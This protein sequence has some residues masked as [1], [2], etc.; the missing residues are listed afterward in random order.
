MA[1]KTLLLMVLLLVYA[2]TGNEKD[3]TQT[4]PDVSKGWPRIQYVSPSIVKLTMSSGQ[5]V[6]VYGREDLSAVEV[7]LAQK[8][9]PETKEDYMYVEFLN[10]HL[11]NSYMMLA[12]SSGVHEYT[13]QR[14]GQIVKSEAPRYTPPRGR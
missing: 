2:C 7:D 10:S 8:R 11:P 1:S 4:T 12:D 14:P 13:I 9:K 6:V 3:R 5:S